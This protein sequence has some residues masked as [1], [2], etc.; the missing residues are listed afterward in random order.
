[1]DRLGLLGPLRVSAAAAALVLGAVGILL[2]P[3]S[4]RWAAGLALALLTA[5]LS[6]ALTPLM[7]PIARRW[8]RDDPL[9]PRA[10]AVIALSAGLLIDG[11]LMTESA[12]RLLAALEV[13]RRT[14]APLLLTTVVRKLVDGRVVDSHADQERLVRLSGFAG[15][16]I[17]VQPVRTTRDEADR[18]REVLAPRGVSDLIVVTSPM[19]T[20]RACRVFESRGFRV[21]CV[22][23]VSRDALTR[24]P[25]T[26]DD[27]LS[28]FRAW[29]YEQ[30]AM[31]KWMLLRATRR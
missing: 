1:M 2:P 25:R 13:T 18:A 4:M 12:D 31:G 3:R 26:A 19:H 30:A 5:Y 22:A 6:V 8:V 11:T 16:W 15:A 9:P 21:T 17:P 14:N 20:R 10:L 28:A 23:A 29:I 7:G 24:A 27:R